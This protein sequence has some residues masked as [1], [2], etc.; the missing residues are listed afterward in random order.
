MMDDLL[1]PG[2]GWFQ[3]NLANAPSEDKTA[4]IGS[5]ANNITGRV[6]ELYEQ[7][8]KVDKFEFLEQKGYYK[9]PDDPMLPQGPLERFEDVTEKPNE[10]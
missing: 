6:R 10:V 9:H 5:T 2:K 8:D 3:L 7:S 4:K 1:R